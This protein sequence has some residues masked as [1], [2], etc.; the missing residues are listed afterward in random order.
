MTVR[1]EA[2]LKSI[3]DQAEAL[4]QATRDQALAASELGR[5][6]VDRLRAR[7]ELIRRALDRLGTEAA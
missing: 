2:E 5:C 7:A 6:D 3:G 4:A 1:L